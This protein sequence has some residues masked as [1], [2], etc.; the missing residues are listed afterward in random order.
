MHT[1]EALQGEHCSDVVTFVT[2]GTAKDSAL[3]LLGIKAYLWP[4]FL[5]VEWDRKKDPQRTDGNTHC[6]EV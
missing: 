1:T 3:G 4:P 5:G 6:Q 2:N